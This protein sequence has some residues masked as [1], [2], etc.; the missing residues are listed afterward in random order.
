MEKTK[1]INELNAEIKLAQEVLKS[2][3]LK[4]RTAKYERLKLIEPIVSI[5]SAIEDVVISKLKKKYAN[6][7]FVSKLFEYPYRIKSV[8]VPE[9]IQSVRQK[10]KHVKVRYWV[11][12]GEGDGTYRLI[13]IPNEYFSMSS[14][15]ISKTHTIWSEKFIEDSIEK[16][17][18]KNRDVKLRKIE[19]LKKELGE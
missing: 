10:T 2:S 8:R 14:E 15:D 7:K 1:T 6:D 9:N 17:I 13:T 12:W 16:S 5:M 18:E 11:D 19:E 3:E 4:L